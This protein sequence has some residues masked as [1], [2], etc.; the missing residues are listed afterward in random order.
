MQVN[1][2][3]WSLLLFACMLYYTG[4]TQPLT[5]AFYAELGFTSTSYQ[6]IKFSEV[7]SSGVRPTIRLGFDKNS[8]KNIWGI[9]MT[10]VSTLDITTTHAQLQQT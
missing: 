2:K 10:M 4:G 7:R 1:T 6:D 3:K 9:N 5:K 8:P